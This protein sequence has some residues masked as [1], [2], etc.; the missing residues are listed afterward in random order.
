MKNKLF[1]FTSPTCP[2]C[3]SYKKFVINNNL[4][5]TI[6]EVNDD[7]TRQMALEWKVHSVPQFVLQDDSFI[8]EENKLGIK[9][10]AVDEV[11]EMLDE[12]KLELVQ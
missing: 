12:N 9:F 7:K 6:V 4:M 11:V 8:N 3:P 2:K 1:L 5:C 10:L